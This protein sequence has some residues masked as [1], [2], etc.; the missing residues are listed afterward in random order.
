M[1]Q[2]ST[3]AHHA[4]ERD[5]LQPQ[6][7]LF[8]FH[9]LPDTDEMHPSFGQVIIADLTTN[10]HHI[11]IV[12]RTIERQ[13]QLDA[14]RSESRGVSVFG[15]DNLESNV[16]VRDA[17]QELEACG[18]RCRDLHILDCDEVYRA[19]EPDRVGERAIVFLYERLP[20]ETSIIISRY[21]ALL[22]KRPF[23]RCRVWV[24]L[25]DVDSDARL[26]AVEMRGFQF[27]NDPQLGLLYQSGAWGVKNMR[28]P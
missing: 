15:Q 28:M 23:I 20:Q 10:K 9:F 6:K 24:N 7:I 16:I 2:A 26:D 11:R 1:P 8:R 4:Q 14:R 12:K 5:P 25:I 13:Q 21:A 18:Y 17:I 19:K 27:K 3:C 22:L